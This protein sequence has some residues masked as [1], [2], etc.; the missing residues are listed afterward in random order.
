MVAADLPRRPTTSGSPA[1]GPGWSPRTSGRTRCAASGR[2]SAGPGVA[3]SRA[4]SGDGLT[5][6]E[7]ARSP[8]S[9]VDGPP[10]LDGRPADRRACRSI[11]DGDIASAASTVPVVE[12]P[13][14]TLRARHRHDRHRDQRAGRDPGAAPPGRRTAP[15]PAGCSRPA[16][17]P[18]GS[19]RWP[20]VL[21]ELNTHLAEEPT[22]ADTLW[23]IVHRFIIGVHERIAYSKLPE[24][25]F[26]FRWEDGRVRF[27]DNGV[28]RF[29][30]AAIRNEPLAPLTRDLGFWDRDSDGDGA[31]SRHARAAAFIAEALRVTDAAARRPGTARIKPIAELFR[32]DCVALWAT[33]YNLDLALFN[34]YLLRRLGDPP[35]NAVVLADRDRLDDT[36]DAIPPERL[37]ILGPVNRRWL[38]RGA[39]VGTG[40]FHPK[41]YLAVTARTA[42][43]LVGSGN[44]ST[45]GID[46]GREVF[47]AFVAGTPH[48]DAA[49][50]T[51]RSM[52]AAPHRRRRRHPPRRALH[53]PRGAPAEAVRTD[54]RSPTRRCGTTSTGPWPTSSATPSLAR[55]D[56]STS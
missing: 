21:A 46:A 6:D 41:S 35:L 52:D 29:P 45:N 26:R 37:D 24:H 43:L 33:T 19:R 13:L 30:L 7:F 2:S 1:S 4:G 47:T 56:R 55:A 40:R 3:A 38:L 36:L 11:A 44:L 15:T 54:R 18:P 49:I 51:W 28:G 39:R 25:T 48:G 22:V 27:F 16:S 53:R 12:A 23:W 10:A 42:K 34:E 14:E 17:G 20:T 9:M 8:A 32:A 50:A 5:W 31:S